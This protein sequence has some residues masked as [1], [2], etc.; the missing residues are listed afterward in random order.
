MKF[1][2]VHEGETYLYDQPNKHCYT[3]DSIAKVFVVGKSASLFSKSI[4][5]CKP[6]I[7]DTTDFS[8][9]MGIIDVSPNDL[10][11]YDPSK[12]IIVRYPENIPVFNA[13]DRDIIV[14]LVNI[15]TSNPQ[16]R[17][18]L[19]DKDFVNLLSLTNKVDFYYKINFGEN[20]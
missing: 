8:N 17:D 3:E 6:Y 7:G 11:P 9:R 12:N 14:K 16:V 20:G 4:I 15:A 10:Y 1:K 19:G 13:S 18:I 5:K 2:D